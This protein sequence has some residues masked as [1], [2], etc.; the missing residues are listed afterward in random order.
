MSVPKGTTV[1]E[2]CRMHD[3]SI[4]TPESVMLPQ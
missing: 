4:P 3:I 2:A 1:L